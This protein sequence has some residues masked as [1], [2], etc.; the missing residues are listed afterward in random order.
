VD[1]VTSLGGIP[2][3]TDAWGLDAV[4]AGS[5]KCLSCAPGLSPVTFSER[6]V[7]RIKARKTRVASWFF[8]L[9]LVMGYWGAGARRAY[10]HT[11]P[12][13]ALYGLHEA[14]ALLHEEG[15]EASWARHERFHRMLRAGL[16]VLGFE[17]LVREDARLPQLNA[18]K[19]PA[20]VDDARLRRILLDRHNLEIGAGLGVLAGKIVRIG[21]MGYSCNL[22]NVLFCLGALEETLA[23]LKQPVHMGEALAAADSVARRG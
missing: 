3:R 19:L 6:A 20:G 14:L 12:V 11:A 22:K 4:Y 5:Q 8:D 21:L 13:H 1:A 10:H 15:L 16:E 18:V 2:L 23:E 9:N 7:E 17:F